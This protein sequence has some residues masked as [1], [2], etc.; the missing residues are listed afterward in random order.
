VISF[1]GGSAEEISSIEGTIEGE[2]CSSSSLS[3]VISLARSGETG[4]GLVSAI[5][6]RSPISA[7]MALECSSLIWILA[8]SLATIFLAGSFGQR[9]LKNVVELLVVRISPAA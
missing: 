9:I 1:N 8:R 7:Q 5:R 6:K 4:A 2:A 3:R